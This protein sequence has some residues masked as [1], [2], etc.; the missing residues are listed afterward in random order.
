MRKDSPE[1]I[2]RRAIYN[3]NAKL[4]RGNTKG[5]RKEFNRAWSAQNSGELSPGT[6]HKIDWMQ[7]KYFH[8]GA[9]CYGD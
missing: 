2:A 1:F 6:A 4:K 8:V 3:C 5:A 9:D 7:E